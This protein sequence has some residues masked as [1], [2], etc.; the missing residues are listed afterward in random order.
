MGGKSEAGTQLDSDSPTSYR[1]V[2][3]NTS[4]HAT[5][6]TLTNDRTPPKQMTSLDGLIHYTVTAGH[7][8]PRSAG[9]FICLSCLIFSAARLSPWNRQAFT[10]DPCYLLKPGDWR[11]PP[12]KVCFGVCLRWGKNPCQNKRL[13]TLWI[14]YISHV[15]M[16]HD[17][18]YPGGPLLY[19][20][21]SE[22]FLAALGLSGGCQISSASTCQFT[23]ENARVIS[24]GP[25]RVVSP[26]KTRCWK[27]SKTSENE[28][29]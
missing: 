18:T 17:Q 12:V 8:C 7:F 9:L 25:C 3:C 10:F 5:T 16:T 19:L 22:G 27:R 4:T 23:L 1:S 26:T 20:S 28:S 11:F 6:K 21:Q 15:K 14:F 2:T 24:D 13:L 29:Q